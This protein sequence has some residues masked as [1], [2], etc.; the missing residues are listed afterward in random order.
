M[1]FFETYN[2]IPFNWNKKNVTLGEL[3]D[4]QL[5]K[6]LESLN[7]NPYGNIYG[8]TKRSY[9]EAISY[10][11]LRRKA[12]VNKTLAANS[13]VSKIFNKINYAK[14][15]KTNSSTGN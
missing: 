12:N 8:N 15:Y 3:N 1:N 9:I 14:T 6:A 2:K 13:L 7:K 4:S 5:K 10:I 11:L